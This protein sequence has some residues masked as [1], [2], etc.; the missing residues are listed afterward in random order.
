[1]AVDASPS[2]LTEEYLRTVCLGNHVERLPP[3]LRDPFVR[4]VARRCPQP[5]ELDYV[6][7][8]MVARR[9]RR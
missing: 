6:R 4:A 1:M 2:M 8:N 9:P 7:L 3:D 5:L